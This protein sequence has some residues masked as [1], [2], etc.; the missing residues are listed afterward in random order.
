[1][2]VQLGQLEAEVRVRFLDQKMCLFIS[3][4]ESS[5]TPMFIAALFIVA[6]GGTNCVYRR[7]NEQ[8]VVY[9]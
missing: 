6:K 3:T 8:D 2:P 7:M 5:Y 9:T 1:M 4:Q